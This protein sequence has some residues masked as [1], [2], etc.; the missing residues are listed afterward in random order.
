MS[1]AGRFSSGYFR[2]MTPDGRNFILLEDV[3]FQRPESVGGEHI[4]IPRGTQS[5]GA[6]TPAALWAL[7]LP[8]FGDHWRA[9][10]VHDF[11]YRNTLR[12][13]DECD[14]I[15][16]EALVASGVPL[17]RARIFYNGVSACGQ[18]AFDEDRSALAAQTSQKG[19]AA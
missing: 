5:D 13:K 19:S 15:F 16:L 2:V 18:K 17:E 14:T 7:G 12:A 4:C 10:F 8:P 1:D 9:A 11:L 3:W 6:S